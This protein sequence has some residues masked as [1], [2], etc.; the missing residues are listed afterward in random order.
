MTSFC[1]ERFRFKRIPSLVES[2]VS[3]DPLDSFGAKRFNN[4]AVIAIKHKL[5]L[6][7]NVATLLMQTKNFIT[8]SSDEAVSD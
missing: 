1:E 5:K 3:A 2:I 6:K 8:R 7:T 4:I